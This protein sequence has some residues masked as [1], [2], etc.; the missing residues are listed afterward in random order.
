MT[1]L[2][3]ALARWGFTT[4]AISAIVAGLPLPAAVTGALAAAAWTAHLRSP[5]RR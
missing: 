1:T 4:L 2:E 5:R 3:P